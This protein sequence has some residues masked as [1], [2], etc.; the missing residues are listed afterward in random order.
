MEK[1]IEYSNIKPN[2]YSIDEDG[3]IK[4]I[5]TN[6]YLSSSITTDGYYT[7]GLQL[8]DNSR[9]TFYNH[10]LVAITFIPNPNDYPCINHK[11]LNTLNNN[12]DNL[13]W[14]TKEY[15]NK[16]ARDNHAKKKI[17]VVGKGNWSDGNKTTGENNGMHKWTEAQVRELCQSIQNGMSYK[18]ALESS[19]IEVTE[20]N[21]TNLRHIVYGLRWKNI[22]KE[23]DFSNKKHR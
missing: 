10:R 15:N 17:V 20:N 14:C 7:T 11:D 13:E 5:I 2:M 6:R 19:N 9:K 22:S 21:K 16:H 4:N 3:H 12:I 23:Y 8:E 1:I 18:E